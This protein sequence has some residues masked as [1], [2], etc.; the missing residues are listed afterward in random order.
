MFAII[1]AWINFS[2]FASAYDTD[3]WV[4]RLTT[5]VQ[6]VGVVMLALGLPPMFASID[7]GR[8]VDNSVMVARLRR[9][10]GWRWSP[11][12]CARPG[13]S[14]Q[15]RRACLTYAVAISVAQVGWIV[16]DRRRTCVARRRPSP[17]VSSC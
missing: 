2:W 10:C 6:M 4:F 17:V 16:A 11:S 12:G 14:P 8:H 1:W 15:R 7:A 9:R 5:M 3:D 13:R